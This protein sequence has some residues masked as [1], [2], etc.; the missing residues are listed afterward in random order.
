MLTGP[1]P[2]PQNPPNPQKS[3]FPL[4]G[5]GGGERPINACWDSHQRRRS[6][7]DP[8]IWDGLSV[9]GPSRI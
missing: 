3:I 1:L 4:G 7:S 5:G 9:P 6:A 2:D 8:A